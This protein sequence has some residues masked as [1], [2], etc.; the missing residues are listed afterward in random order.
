MYRYYN[1]NKYHRNIEDCAIRSIS[2]ATEKSWDEIYDELANAGKELGL[3]MDSVESIEYYL[4]SKFPRVCHYSK[5]LGEFADEFPRGRFVVSMD[6]HL[7][8][9]VDGDILDTFD[10]SN[11]VIRCSWEVL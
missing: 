1:A 8:T 2:K 9:V 11:K 6:G 4:D 10:P 5:T 3:M 7:S